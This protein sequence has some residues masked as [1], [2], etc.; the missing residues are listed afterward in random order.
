MEGAMM[1]SKLFTLLVLSG[2]IGCCI[3]FLTVA[4]KMQNG[5]ALVMLLSLSVLLLAM[6]AIWTGADILDEFERKL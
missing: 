4:V 2:T 6:C 5:E 3:W 1:K